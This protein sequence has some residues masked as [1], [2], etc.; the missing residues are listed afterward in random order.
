MAKYH[1]NDNGVTAECGAAKG[2]CPFGGVSGVENHFN[3]PKEARTAY[4]AKMKTSTFPSI[5]AH[6]TNFKNFSIEEYNEKVNAQGFLTAFKERALKK[7]EGKAVA[8]KSNSEKYS[9]LFKKQAV[10]EQIQA[11]PTTAARFARTLAGHSLSVDA[12]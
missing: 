3:T 4:E 1:I 10:A 12:K 7:G 11:G 8:F 2:K 6:Q 9:T 5:P